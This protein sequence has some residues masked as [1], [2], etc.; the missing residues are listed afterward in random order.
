ME[1]REEE[2][3]DRDGNGDDG[4]DSG[5]RMKRKWR[6]PST[7]RFVVVVGGE[8]GLTPLPGTPKEKKA[9]FN[10]PLLELSFLVPQHRGSVLSP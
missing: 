8:R 5:Q 3:E 4:L 1:I 7:G 2:E 10:W 6:W 9:K